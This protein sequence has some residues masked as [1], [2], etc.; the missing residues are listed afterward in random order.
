MSDFLYLLLLV[1]VVGLYIRVA[2][3]QGVHE[4]HH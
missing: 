1:P 4:N 2:H 3:K